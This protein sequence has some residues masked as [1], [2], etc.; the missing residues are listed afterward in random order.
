M[1][2][3]LNHID[4]VPEDRREGML[5]DVR[6][7]LEADGLAG[8]PVLGV[9]ARHGIGIPE[10]KSAIAARVAEKKATRARLAAD[11]RSAAE[12]V[13]AASGTARTRT[14][15]PERVAA[16]D[17]AFADAA[18]V[19]TVVRAVETSTRMR[20]NR[21]T[22]W[23]VVAW[24]SKL[25]P[26]PLKRL[27]LDLGAVGKELTGS[28]RTSVPQATGVQRARV[29]TEVRA[30]ADQVSDGMAPAWTG[31]IR[32]A[33]VSRLPDLGDRLD[34]AVASTD[35][36]ADKIP[37]WAGLVRVLQWALILTAI[38]GVV[39]LGALFGVGLPRLRRAAP[40]PS[41]A[42]SRSP[43]SCSSAA[44]GSGCSW[45]WSAGCSSRS[46]RGSARARPTSGCATR[47][48][49][50]PRRSSWS[51]IRAELAAYAV[52]SD[53]LAAALK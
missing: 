51:P 43:R 44:S 53:G 31:A 8:V 14:L 22:G 6:R 45:P 19:P 7:L 41:G 26:D 2:V 48:P 20:A 12:R 10:L 32:K 38:A 39:W 28:A 46:P 4:T 47:S 35:L 52:V 1:M 49:R 11:L 13:Q 36:G 27:H 33:S 34:R 37:V 18:G 16:L 5:A 17:D 50:S 42:G 15:S 21:A 9:S 24:F 3:V 25:K 40:R 23:P 29:D 30:L